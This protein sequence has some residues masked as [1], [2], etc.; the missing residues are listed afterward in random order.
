MEVVEVL[1]DGGWM[2]YV[3]LGVSVFALAIILDRFV[4]LFLRSKLDLRKLMGQVVRE[5]EAENYTQAIETC[6]IRTKHPLPMVLKAGLS[7]ANRREKEI[8]RAMEEEMLRALPAIQRGVGLLGFLGNTA[9]LLGLLGTIFGLIRAFNWVN[10]ANATQRQEVLSEGISIALYT[11]AFG[12]IVAVPVLFVHQI[13]AGRVEKLLIQIEEG[14]TALLIALA[15]RMP[16]IKG[17][18]RKHI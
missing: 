10:V 18:D 13:I 9:T 14:A 12:L 4:S 17:T 11:T 16:A 3:I 8:E 2:M 5:V 6:N 7:K 1:K 15:G